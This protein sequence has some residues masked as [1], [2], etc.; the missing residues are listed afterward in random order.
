MSTSYQE[1]RSTLIH[2]PKTNT[3]STAVDVNATPQQAW[4]VVG[5]FAGFD[6][7]VDG[8][9][10]I[11]MTGEGVRAVRKKHFAD[12]HV[13]LEQLNSYDEDNFVMSWSLIYTNMDINNL[14]S[15]MHVEALPDGSAR[16]YWDIA[17][18]PS[19]SDTRQPDFEDYI[20]TF[21]TAALANAKRLI[22]Q[23]A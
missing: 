16:V 19:N 11:E 18:E 5:N 8:L 3:V 10:S 22:E 20:A 23:A 2:T 4:Q 15:A 6:K 13:V 17:G 9:E 1:Q 14:W 12:G 7:F 21:A